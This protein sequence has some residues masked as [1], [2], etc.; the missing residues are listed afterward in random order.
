MHDILVRPLHYIKVSVGSIPSLGLFVW[1]FYFDSPTF[2]ISKN[3]LRQTLW[4]LKRHPIEKYSCICPLAHHERLSSHWLKSRLQTAIQKICG[5]PVHSLSRL[6]PSPLSLSFSL[7]FTFSLS[8]S[9]FLFLSISSSSSISISISAYA[10]IPHFRSLSGS[11]PLVL[12]AYPTSTFFSLLS[13][14]FSFAFF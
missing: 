14:Y 2:W 9:L 10:H 3:L 6:S 4:W 11:A 5:T 1:H 13:V 8:H 7:F 12:S